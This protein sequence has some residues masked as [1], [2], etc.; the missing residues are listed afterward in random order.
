MR[1]GF[2]LGRVF[3]L[4]IAEILNV[5]EKAES[6]FGLFEN[7]IKI[8]EVSKEI[9]IIETEKPLLVEPLQKKLGGVIKIVKI[10]DCLE[11]RKQDSL[12]FALRNYFKPSKLK[13][14]F[15]KDYKGKKQFGVSVYVI[16]DELTF[17]DRHKT[18][19][20]IPQNKAETRTVWG[21]PKRV[22]MMIK[23]TLTENNISVRL[24][25]PEENSLSLTSVSV[26]KN[27]LLEK[28][29]EICLLASKDRLY[30]A[31]TL[32]V[33]DFEDY[34]RRDYQRPIRDE[35]QGMI[36]PKVAQSMLNLCNA[37]PNEYILDPF[38]GIGTVI[39]EGILLG[40][41]MFGSDINNLA[42]RGS[43]QNLEWF[44][45]RYHIPHGKFILNTCD[46]KKVSTL[47]DKTTINSIV[48]ECT[49]GPIYSE[50]PKSEEIEENFKVLESLYIDCFKDFAKF[51][52]KQARIVM[53]IPAYRKGRDSYI[54]MKSIDFIKELGYNSIDL[55]SKKSAKQMKFLKLTE[56]GTVIYDRKDQIVAREIVI[57]EKN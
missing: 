2:I 7:P 21:E 3:T 20:S 29:A 15:F 56:R 34:G 53:C 30:V 14:D 27:Q 16:D 4:S 23:K 42:I 12:N 55:I 52:P 26:N 48:T 9:L 51:L 46:A 44:R 47:I 35:K 24:V 39:Q 50:F 1:Y 11:K 10:I 5:L 13:N 37:K 33:Q 31:K 57:F 8:I 49:L 45:N 6:I 32:C 18:H 28:G 25:L 41:K 17:K 54:K 38:C 40:Y 43:E 22:G 36:P 19:N